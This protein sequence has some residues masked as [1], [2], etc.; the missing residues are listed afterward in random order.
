MRENEPL[1]F[2]LEATE[3]YSQNTA[4]IFQ[5]KSYLITRPIPMRDQSYQIKLI[6]GMFFLFFPPGG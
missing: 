1:H 6:D 2:E 5:P 4:G 3:G